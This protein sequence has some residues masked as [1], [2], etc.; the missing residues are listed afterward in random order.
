VLRYLK[1][2][3]CNSCH[4]L[5][6]KATRELEPQLARSKPRRRRGAP[7]PI[8]PAGNPHGAALGDF[9]SSR[10]LENFGDWTDRIAK[11]E[12]PFAKPSRPTGIERNVVLTLWI[13]R[14]DLLH[15]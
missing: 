5:G 6:D 1:T 9:N 12:L 14:R 4:Q 2:D 3:G 13:G 7:H 8:R 10:A 11:G 15:A